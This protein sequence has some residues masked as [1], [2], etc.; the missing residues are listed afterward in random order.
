MPATIGL[1]EAKTHLS[2]LA[3]RVAAGEEI[4]VTDRGKPVMKLV[5]VAEATDQAHA[6]AAR[7][8]DLR[9]RGSEWRKQQGEPPLSLDEAI[10]LAREGR[11]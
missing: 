1:F 5:P 7:L 9:R 3:R 2:A 10:A 11:R 8:E 4:V 6:F